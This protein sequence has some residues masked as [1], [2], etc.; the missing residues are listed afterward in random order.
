MVISK[1]G[2]WEVG[3][4]EDPPRPPTLAH[5]DSWSRSPS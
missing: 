3:G 5:S 1:A 4:W 2:V